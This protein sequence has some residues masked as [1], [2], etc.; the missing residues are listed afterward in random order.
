LRSTTPT[1]P[2]SAQ[3]RP[4]SASSAIRRASFVAVKMRRRQALSYILLGSSHV[5]TPRQ[6]S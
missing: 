3:G 2:K 4:E 5:A 1:L 6:T